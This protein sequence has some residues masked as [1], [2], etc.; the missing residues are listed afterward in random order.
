[1]PELQQAMVDHFLLHGTQA[2]EGLELLPG[3]RELLTALQVKC[4]TCICLE[5][6]ACVHV[7][8]CDLSYVMTCPLQ[9]LPPRAPTPMQARDDVLACLVT[10]NMQPIG[11]AKMEALGIRHLFT[12][13]PFGGF[14]SDFCSGDVPADIVDSWRDRAE[15]VRVAARRAE[16]L[17]PGGIGARFHVGDAPM[18]VLAAEA[19]GA[20]AVGV[21]TGI[22]SRE[23][24]AGA[25]E[26]VVVL[27]GLAD[28]EKV[29]QVL[30]LSG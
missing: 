19:A 8:A 4:L 22:Y 3:V 6:E 15:L 21:T 5:M 14:G 9:H 13:P 27:D 28:L 25:G 18:D 12:Q 24:L 2:G 20:V 26:R 29:L 23:T 11:W 30:Q 10:G 17:F 7:T 1:M 16:E